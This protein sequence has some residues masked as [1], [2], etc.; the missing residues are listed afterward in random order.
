MKGQ[1]AKYISFGTMAI[2]VIVLVCATVAEKFLGTQA[3]MRHVYSSPVFVFLWGI[4]AI[5][6]LLWLFRCRMMRRPAT[7]MIHLSL[8]LILAGGLLTWLTARYGTMHLREGDAPQDAFVTDEGQ[9][10]HLP[11]SLS[12]DD[13][14]VEYYPGTGTPKDF[15][16]RLVVD[17]GPGKETGAG[18]TDADSSI[19]DLVGS[20]G[21]MVQEASVSMNRI[22][23]CKGFR[24]YQSSYDED[25]AGTVL[26][27]SHDPYG[28]AVTY[29]G[30]ALLLLSILLFFLQRD[31]GFRQALK[32]LSSTAIAFA[33]MLS[34]SSAANAADVITTMPKALPAETAAEF[35]SIY[36][37]YN[38]RI[39]PMQ[40]LARDFTLKLYGKASYRGLSAEQVLTGWMFYYD[41]WLKTDFLTAK[42]RKKPA[43]ADD[44]YEA[45]RLVCSAE[46]L[47]IFPYMENLHQDERPDFPDEQGLQ[48]P[49][50][51]DSW[52]L[53][54]PQGLVWY[55]PSGNIPVELPADE[56]MFVRRV[57]SLAGESVALGRF[58]ETKEI[59]SKIR[60]YQVKTAGSLL[61]SEI[62]MKAEKLYNRI[63]RPMA[64]AMI[65]VTLGF[66]LF[67]LMSVLLASEKQSLSANGFHHSFSGI[68]SGHG[69]L[70]NCRISMHKLVFTVTDMAGAAVFAYLTAVLALRWVASG[71]IPMSNGF[72]TMMMLG[73]TTMLVTLISAH[74]VSIVRPFGFLLCGF[75]LLVASIGEKDPQITHL[76]P[77]LSSPLLSLHVASMMISYSLLGLLALN[78]IM[79]ITVNFIN[80]RRSRQLAY[81]D[82]L[83]AT[84][85]EGLKANDGKGSKQA[86]PLTMEAD[87][88]TT[89][90]MLSR[91]TDTSPAVRHLHDIGLVILYP[92]LFTLAI[93]IFLG[94]VWANISW[95]RYWGWDPKEVWALITMLV[96]ASA[97]HCNS[98]K[99]FRNPVFFH[100]FCILAFLCVLITYFGVNLVLGGLHGYA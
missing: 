90:Y 35:G 54:K 42:D 33:L 60:S 91:T 61:P 78:G 36:V 4:A 37:Y 16:S 52:D 99:V 27:V 23:S 3:V 38:G 47:K 29:S 11:F 65:C 53:K 15:R 67:I 34:F 13:F 56:W 40:T 76:M 88:Q 73:W 89:E 28:I 63:G 84:P 85:Q 31:S 64:A 18:R 75:S 43:K 51:Y 93:G 20:S 72:E 1:I 98:L 7:M 69:F 66:I 92:A 77:V 95:G 22:F 24:F 25:E 74:R 57:M 10:V 71:H 12:L 68:K 81:D 48:T 55:S 96:Y 94:A 70:G 2:V 45:I 86:A 41:S 30:Y 6:A 79:G 21:N 83:P 9:P 32:R 8:I 97:L 39:A 5:S 82:S 87:R 80:R 44:K 50:N 100:R 17:Y 19:R 59:F 58:S 14:E 49:G 46:I 62:V 26:S